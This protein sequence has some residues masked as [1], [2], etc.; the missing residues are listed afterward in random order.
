MLKDY[1]TIL[2]GDFNIEILKKTPQLTTF[3]NLM[4]K[5]KLNLTFTESTTIDN[6]QINHTSVNS[7]HNAPRRSPPPGPSHFPLRFTSTY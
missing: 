5:Y 2:I 7:V 6:T 4:Y 3:Q 1:L